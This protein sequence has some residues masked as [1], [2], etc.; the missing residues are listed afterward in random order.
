[1]VNATD[2]AAWRRHVANIVTPPRV[3]IG[4]DDLAAILAMIPDPD[5]PTDELAQA[6]AEAAEWRAIA[7]AVIGPN[8][9]DAVA[10]VRGYI[11]VVRHVDGAPE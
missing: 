11:V 4:K 10:E 7:E 9:A 6:R 3:S 1:V 5:D 8:A 2:L